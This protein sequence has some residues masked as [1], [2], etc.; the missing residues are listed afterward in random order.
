MTDASLHFVFGFGLILWP[1]MELF[2]DTFCQKWFA[3]KN[4]SSKGNLYLMIQFFVLEGSTIFK[5]FKRVGLR[6]NVT[7]SA[8]LW[9]R[10]FLLITLKS[11][12][13][14]SENIMPIFV[15]NRTNFVWKITHTKGSQNSTFFFA[16]WIKCL[17]CLFWSGKAMF[18]RYCTAYLVFPALC[19]VPDWSL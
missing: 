9:T 14:F 17:P 7:Q 8:W 2:F 10:C 5:Q 13:T 11:F 19:L 1:R 15:K 16:A 4:L 12:V 3:W 6:L 18:F